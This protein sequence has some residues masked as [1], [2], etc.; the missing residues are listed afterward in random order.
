MKNVLK[1]LAKRVSV[2]LG[3]TAAVS[4]TDAVIPFEPSKR[5]LLR[6]VSMY[7]RFASSRLSTT[8]DNINI[9]KDNVTKIVKS[10]KVTGL[11]TKL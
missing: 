3:L 9:F 5:K 7:V 11:L 2:R 1:P 6:W 8:N 10:I 4:D